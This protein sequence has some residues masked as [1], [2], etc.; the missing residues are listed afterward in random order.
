LTSM[1]LGSHSPHEP[2]DELPWPVLEGGE[3]S[4][5]PARGGRRA[6]PAHL[7]ELA[8]EG[9]AGARLD[10]HGHQCR[11]RETVVGCWRG[12]LGREAPTLCPPGGAATEG[13]L[14]SSLD[15]M[16]TREAAQDCCGVEEGDFPLSP[17][18][19]GAQ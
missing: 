12:R 10:P 3:R 4:G 13:L 9:G 8:V 17:L 5:E 16:G 1:P 15:G 19:C 18:T 6:P 7:H 2:G 14:G 11:G